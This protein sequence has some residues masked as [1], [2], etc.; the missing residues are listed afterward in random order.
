MMFAVLDATLVCAKACSL[1]QI[2]ELHASLSAQTASS[3]KQG[4][5]CEFAWKAL[6]IFSAQYKQCISNN[7]HCSLRKPKQILARCLWLWTF[8]I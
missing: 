6:C 3:F 1:F 7:A 8:A 4:H 2:Y 5:C